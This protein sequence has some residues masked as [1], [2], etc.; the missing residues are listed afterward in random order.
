M[1]V[2]VHLRGVAT[3]SQGHAESSDSNDST[4]PDNVVHGMQ[5]TEAMNAETVGARAEHL[6]S[7]RD[8]GKQS[9][10]KDADGWESRSQGNKGTGGS[11]SATAAATSVRGSAV[12]SKVK[13]MKQ[14]GLRAVPSKVDFGRVA[15]GQELCSNVKVRASNR[16]SR[17][18]REGCACVCL[19]VT[20]T[21]T[22]THSLSLSL[23]LS[24]WLYA[25][26]SLC[27][28]LLFPPNSTLA[29][30]LFTA[31]FAMRAQRQASLGL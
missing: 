6:K 2:A 21:H 24:L 23:S 18:E 22:H 20:H 1:K 11:H 3:R 31:R 9:H 17:G 5:P 14:R 4:V 19:F 7:A 28:S 16:L 15:L 13:R 8:A 29:C 27:D 26:V 25:C 30:T 10:S 12:Q